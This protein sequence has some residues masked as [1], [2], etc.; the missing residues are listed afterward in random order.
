MTTLLPTIAPSDDVAVVLQFAAGAALLG[1]AVAARRRARD[2]GS[3]TWL[4]T[5]R[6]TTAGAA[7]GVLY[8]LWHG[9]T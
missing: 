5:A 4:I 9:L 3:D 7:V 6:W 1:T 8:L 2:P